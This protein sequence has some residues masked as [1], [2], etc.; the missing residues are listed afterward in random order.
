MQSDECDTSQVAARTNQQTSKEKMMRKQMKA[1]DMVVLMM[2]VMTVTMLDRG[3]CDHE[4]EAFV[5]IDSV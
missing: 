5:R 2:M 4:S 3:Q 1:M